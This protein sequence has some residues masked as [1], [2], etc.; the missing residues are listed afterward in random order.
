MTRANPKRVDLTGQRFGRWLVLYEA[1]QRDINRNRYWMCHCDCG[2]EK[3]VQ[4][5][6]LRLGITASCGCANA[7]KLGMRMRTHNLT[8][9]REYNS[10]TT[11]IQRC[12]NPNN[13]G[14]YLYGG[15]GITVCER[16]KTFAN[17]YA[18]MGPRPS[19]RHSLDR[20]D[21]SGPYA[22]KN[23]RWATLEEQANNTRK[24]IY[25]EHDGKRLTAAQWARESRVKVGQ[26][27]WRLKNGWSI[28]E[29]ISIP[30][31]SNKWTSR[32]ARQRQRAAHSE[33]PELGLS[34]SGSRGSVV[35]A[36]QQP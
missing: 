9:S 30:V 12:T 27:R 23:C 20:T 31:S 1:E 22:P 18:D 15:R 14:Y 35:P 26:L 36:P 17:F 8:N 33:Q 29:A 19:S 4:Q 24:N 7:G 32:R 11:M 21:N 10:W 28:A 5:G 16:W 34:Q 6:G 25:Y 3:T 2:T 13:D